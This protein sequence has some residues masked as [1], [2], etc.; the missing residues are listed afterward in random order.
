MGGIE[1][2]HGGSGGHGIGEAGKTFI[3]MTRKDEAAIMEWPQ[4]WI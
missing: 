2:W 1:S 4:S 3:I